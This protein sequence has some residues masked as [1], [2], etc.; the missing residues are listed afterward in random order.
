VSSIQELPVLG[1]N[2]V[3]EQVEALGEFIDRGFIEDIHG[4]L[5]SGKEATVYLCEAP[6]E[7]NGLLA[8]KVYRSRDVRRFGN[9]AV[10]TSGRIREGHR[11]EARALVHK[12]RAG[13]EMAFERWVRDEY[14]TLV[15]LHRAGCRV[16]RPVAQS[17]TA[18]LMEYIGDEDEPAPLLAHSRLSRDEARAAWEAVLRDVELMLGC[19][20]VHGDLSPFNVLYWNDAVTII[21]FPQAVD[22][23][24]NQNAL[25]LLERDL[26]R[27]AEFVARCGFDADARGATRSLWARFLRSDL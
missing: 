11:R 25:P 15:L 4:V 22:A 5:K 21:D 7:A 9:D 8:A 6:A 17:S 1:K 3:A 18:V 2:K 16:P 10:Y 26:E 27:I 12:S 13:R 24:F 20:R 23:R 19:D 14:E